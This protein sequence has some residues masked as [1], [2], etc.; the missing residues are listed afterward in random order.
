[1]FSRSTLGTIYRRFHSPFPRVPEWMLERLT[2]VDHRDAESL[3]VAVVG[4]EIVG[5]AL[6]VLAGGGREAEAAVVFEDGWQS[7]GSGNSCSASS[8][9]RAG[10]GVARSSPA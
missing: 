4:D 3:L 9:R 10:G 2:N 5:H 1:M 6:Y 8:L 7:R